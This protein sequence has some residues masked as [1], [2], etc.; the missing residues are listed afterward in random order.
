M[1]LTGNENDEKVTIVD[2]LDVYYE[3]LH[4]ISKFRRMLLRLKQTEAG[5]KEN[6]KE[7]QN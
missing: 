3:Y 5:K 2:D 7:M 4:I 1:H 6:T